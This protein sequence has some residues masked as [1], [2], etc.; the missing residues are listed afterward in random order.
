[1]RVLATINIA[2]SSAQIVHNHRWDMAASSC[3]AN[4]ARDPF[5]LSLC[6]SRRKRD[7]ASE[8]SAPRS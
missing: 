7:D 8:C 5:M 4:R 3:R 2:S 6:G 1:M